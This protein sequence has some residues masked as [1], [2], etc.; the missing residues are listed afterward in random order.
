MNDSTFTK[1]DNYSLPVVDEET[2]NQVTSPI[3]SREDLRYATTYLSENNERL[4]TAIVKYHQKIGRNTDA[5]V[6]AIYDTMGLM[7]ELLKVQLE[8]LK[9]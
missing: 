9:K 2:V 4:V 3:K 1:D 7:H 6:Q 8:K 5:E